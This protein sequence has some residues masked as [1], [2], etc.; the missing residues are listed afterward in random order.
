MKRKTGTADPAWWIQFINDEGPMWTYET[1][2]YPSSRK[3][4]KCVNTICIPAICSGPTRALGLIVEKSG[5]YF[6]YSNVG[7]DQRKGYPKI[8]T[9]RFYGYCDDMSHGQVLE[10][11]ILVPNRKYR[12][13]RK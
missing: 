1:D 5:G 10:V 6:Y 2:L 9:K 3:E 8:E 12:R 7:D 13:K 11:M 4:T